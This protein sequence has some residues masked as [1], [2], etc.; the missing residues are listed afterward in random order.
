MEDFPILTPPLQ[1]E[2]LSWLPCLITHSS[3]CTTATVCQKSHPVLAALEDCGVFPSPSTILK[4]FMR[5][6]PLTTY[7]A[8]KESHCGIQR[9][10]FKWFILSHS[11]SCTAAVLSRRHTATYHMGK[12]SHYL[13]SVDS[14]SAACPATQNKDLA[15]TPPKFVSGCATPSWASVCCV[16]FFLGRCEQI[17]IYP[18]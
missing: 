16:D 10:S 15:V 11:K 13:L 18:R 17:L 3:G 5:Q 7:D 12:G 14:T 4:V 6:T 8:E 9:E 1:N 2:I